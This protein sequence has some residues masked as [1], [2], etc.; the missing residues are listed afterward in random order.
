FAQRGAA[1]RIRGARALGREEQRLAAV[2][3]RLIDAL[4]LRE[5]ATPGPLRLWPR[6]E[7]GLRR[8]VGLLVRCTEEARQARV[9][10]ERQHLSVGSSTVFSSR[11]SMRRVTTFSASSRGVSGMTIA[12]S[13]PP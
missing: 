9:L 8:V 7:A 11:I 6:G 13:S 3:L 5:L 2:Q 12:N 1:E 10:R 4:A